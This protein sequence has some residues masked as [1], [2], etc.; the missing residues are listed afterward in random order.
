[1]YI[2]QI[3]KLRRR[4]WTETVSA[5]R[6]GGGGSSQMVESS[7]IS[8]FRE[9]L[10]IPSSPEKPNYR[11]FVHMNVRLCTILFVVLMYH[12]VTVIF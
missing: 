3:S 4:L 6:S 11:K 2:R 1:V 5:T 9:N 10:L 8:A 7:T 12:I